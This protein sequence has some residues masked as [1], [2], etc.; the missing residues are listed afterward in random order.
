[1]RALAYLFLTTIKNSLKE[2]K[3]NPGKLVL[4]V[5]FVVLVGVS[6]VSGTA[7]PSSQEAGYRDMGELYAIVFALYILSFYMGSLKGLGSGASFYSMA[8]VSHLFLA[9]I[10]PRRILVYGLVKQ[11]GTTLWIGFF[12]LFQYG[13][14]SNTYGLSFGGLIA[15]LLGFSAVVFCAQVTAMAIYS[16]SS[17]SESRRK[18]IKAVLIL[19]AVLIA[20]GILLPLMQNS[21]GNLLAEALRGINADWVGWLPVFGWMKLAVQSLLSAEPLLA[22]A[23]AG[24][25]VAYV[26]ALVFA[27]TRRNADF[28]EDVL[29]A[30]E[31]SFTAITAKKEGQMRDVLPAKVKVGKT[32]LGHGRGPDAFYYKHLLENRRAKLFILDTTSLIF[33]GVSIFFTVFV[34]DAGIVGVFAFCTYMQIFS[35]MTGRW[36]KEL[37]LPY[38]YMVPASPF[39]KLLAICREGAL[40]VCVEAVVLFVPVGLILGLSV[41]EILACIAARIGFGV[42]FIAGNILI[43]RVLGSM[44]SKTLIVFLYFIIMILIAVPGI[45]LGI[46]AAMLFPAAGTVVLP[47]LGMFVWNALASVLI[48]Y[49]CRNI[50]DYAE[51]NNR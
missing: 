37:L 24:L 32:G 44:V 40:K 1:M 26:C 39:Q 16:Y 38:V 36:L 17:G 30:T 20:A 41:P 28:Y 14:L 45:V 8:D 6:L 11:M 23:G 15:I 46:G 50:L 5:V 25:A 22:L 31:V 2:L 12:L 43:E 35:S 9:P 51:L 7:G 48:V 3:K 19:S 42:L 27:M 21:G 29:Q 10:A 34:R 18:R 13:W 47:M 33:I 4:V 49:L